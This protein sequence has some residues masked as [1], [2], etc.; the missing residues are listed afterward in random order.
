[1][2]LAAKKILALLQI[3]GDLGLPVG[4][5]IRATIGCQLNL[6][7]DVLG[8]VVNLCIAQRGK[9]GHATLRATALHH[10]SDALTFLIVQD[11]G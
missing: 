7:M 6:Q 3:T 4:L 1:V 8:N 11:Q 10:R 5:P 2:Q 9:S